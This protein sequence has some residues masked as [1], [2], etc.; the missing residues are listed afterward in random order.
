M[1]GCGNSS[2]PLDLWKEGYRDITSIDLSPAVIAK[3]EARSQALVSLHLLLPP[4]CTGD[5]IMALMLAIL[6]VP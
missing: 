6:T 3:M 2:L 4:T 1:L 5:C